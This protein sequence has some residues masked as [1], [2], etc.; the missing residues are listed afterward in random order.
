MIQK[1]AFKN[2]LL[3]SFK[4]LKTA[5]AIAVTEDLETS[6]RRSIEDYCKILRNIERERDDL[7]LNLSPTSIGTNSVVP[8]GFNTDKFLTEDINLGLKQRETIIHLEIVLDRYQ[9]LFGPITDT[10]AILK[11]LPDWKPLD[12]IEEEEG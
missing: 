10:T 6:Y 1:N 4:D 9:R 8:T 5:K 12:F 3:R 2:S 11:V 7:I